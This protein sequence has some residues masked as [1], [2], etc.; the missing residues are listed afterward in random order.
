MSG[1]NRVLRAEIKENSKN[2]AGAIIGI[3]IGL[4]FLYI[5]LAKTVMAEEG[6]SL[7]EFFKIIIAA[8]ILFAVCVTLAIGEAQSLGETFPLA[9]KLGNKRSDIALG[10]ILNDILILILAGILMYLVPK[11][12]LSSVYDKI[13]GAFGKIISPSFIINFVLGISSISLISGSIAYIFKV[14]PIIGSAFGIIFAFALFLNGNILNITLISKMYL[15]IA[16]FIIG[17]VLRFYIINKLDAR[18]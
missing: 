6:V 1:I 13:L 4:G 9:S 5:F 2:L 16:L 15:S 14:G 17:Q 12:L 10:L 18:F 3:L 8:M 7:P 11:F